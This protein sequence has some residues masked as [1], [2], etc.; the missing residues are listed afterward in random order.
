MKKTPNTIIDETQDPGVNRV[1]IEFKPAK[2]PI[3]IPKFHWKTDK[4]DARDFIYK[5]NTV[6]PPLTVDLR[7]L[8]STPVE[9]QGNL[10][11]CTGNAIA[12]A[13]ELIDKKNG[14]NTEVS[15]LFI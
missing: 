15:R 14:K 6:V 4:P 8:Y 2:L 5:L 10:G 7:Q 1:P 12:E 9:D 13:I 3:V 11:S